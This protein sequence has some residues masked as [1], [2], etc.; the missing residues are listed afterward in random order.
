MKKIQK[1][2]KKQKTVKNGQKIP[3]ISKNHLK[4]KRKK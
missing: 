1:K 2:S 4:E 3:K